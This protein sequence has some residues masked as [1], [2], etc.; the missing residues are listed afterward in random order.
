[1]FSNFQFT[2]LLLIPASTMG[3]ISE[4]R[5]KQTI[6]LLLS[7]PA[8]S[9]EIV[10]SK[11]AA[12][13]SFISY[14]LLSTVFFLYLGYYGNPDVNIIINFLFWLVASCGSTYKSWGIYFFLIQK[15]DY[16]LS[17]IY[18]DYARANG[19]FMGFDQGG[20]IREF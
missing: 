4:E 9:F 8:R 1:M 13:L 20:Y 16:F 5:S 17:R 14:T 11:F 12:I 18:Y 6:R 19:L 10:F 15:A 3:V 7:S 2:L